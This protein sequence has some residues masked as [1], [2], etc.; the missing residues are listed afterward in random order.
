MNIA[1]IFILPSS[2]EGNPK[3]LLEAMSCEMPVI[4][5]DSPGISNLISHNNN[6]YICDSTIDG[7][8][9]AINELINKV[10]LQNKLSKNARRYILDYFSLDLIVKRELEL[11]NEV[12]K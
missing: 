4:G 1:S 3:S 12:L 6:G 11:Y 10:E 7:I 9:K 5:A 8:R 2:F